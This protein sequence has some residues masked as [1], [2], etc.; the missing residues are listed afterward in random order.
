LEVMQMLPETIPLKFVHQFDLTATLEWQEQ[1]KAE[2]AAKGI[3]LE[4]ARVAAQ[5]R[6]AHDP[7]KVHGSVAD[8]FPYHKRAQTMQEWLKGAKEP[9]KAEAKKGR[10][11]YLKGGEFK[12]PAQSPKQNPYGWDYSN[13]G[14]PRV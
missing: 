13:L 3:A 1:Q 9:E 6:L 7:S 12:N 5:Q 2:A 4:A 14:P 11:P 8:L 10:V